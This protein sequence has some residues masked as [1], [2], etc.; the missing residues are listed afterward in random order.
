[1]VWTTHPHTEMSREIGRDRPDPA[2]AW[3]PDRHGRLRTG[4]WTTAIHSF[5]RPLVRASKR[6]I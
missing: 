2:R 4:L 1:M 6:A 3:A 5:L